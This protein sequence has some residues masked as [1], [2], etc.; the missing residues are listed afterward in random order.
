MHQYER[1]LKLH[2]IFKSHR[3]PVDVQRLRDELG[4]SRATLYRDI[5]SGRLPKPTKV[6]RSSRWRFSDIELYR[7]G[8]SSNQE[9]V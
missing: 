5:A 2:G 6:G 3:R 1:V 7:G 8:T 4:C 9:R